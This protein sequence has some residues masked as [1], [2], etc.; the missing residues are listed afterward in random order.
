MYNYSK[1]VLDSTITERIENF[2]KKFSFSI[3][4]NCTKENQKYLENITNSIREQWYK[5]FKLFILVDNENSKEE[6]SKLN[7]NASTI[8]IEKNKLFEVYNDI[9]KTDENDFICFLESYETLELSALYEINSKLNERDLDFIYTNEDYIQNNKHI[10]VNYKSNISQEL[11]L[12][13][14]YIGKSSFFKLS[15]LKKIGGFNDFKDE[16]TF[17]DLNLRLIE[18]NSNIYFLDKVL[19]HID[20]DKKNDFSKSEDK[21]ILKSMLKRRNLDASIEDGL[22]ESS[23]RIKYS[24]K[25]EPLVSIVIPFKDQPHFL[26]QCINSILDLSTYKNFEII[27]ISNNSE[28]EKTFQYMKEFKRKDKRIKFIEHNVAFNFS[29]INNFAVKEHTKGEH[30]IFLN[31]DIKIISENWIES[32]LEFSQQEEIACVGSLLY[33]ENNTIQHCGIKVGGDNIAQHFLAFLKKDSA[34]YSNRELLIQNV[35]AVT[36]A[37]LMIKKDLFLKIG[38]FDENLTVAYNDVDLCIKAVKDGKR[39]IFTPYSKAYHF[40]SVSRGYDK[41]DEKRNRL[42][43]EQNS[44]KEKHQKFLELE[45][46]YIT[47]NLFNEMQFQ[48]HNVKNK[49]IFKQVRIY[50]KPIRQKLK[51]IFKRSK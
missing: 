35:T 23:Y 3:V 7:V 41:S 10:K 4:I 49:N 11:I 25:Y 20:L 18:N 45:D 22:I 2:D 33:Y 17:Y 34:S 5:N 21:L 16:S 19:F 47:D 46:L 27:G 32:M 1:A 48:I 28:E 50:S 37:S 39:N 15:I 14:N 6:I 44:L 9:I 43:R 26:Q 30:I 38:A 31:N 42:I 13:Q 51:N 29:E 36:A 24:I 8:N 40:E 12:S